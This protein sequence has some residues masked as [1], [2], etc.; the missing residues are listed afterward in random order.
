MPNV[1]KVCFLN[2]KIK[3]GKGVICPNLNEVIMEV[4]TFPNI[5]FQEDLNQVGIQFVEA[6]LQNVSHFLEGIKIEPTIKQQL[7]K[8]FEIRNQKKV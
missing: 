3:L 2:C 4:S 8:E 1:Q 7:L 5:S 6:T